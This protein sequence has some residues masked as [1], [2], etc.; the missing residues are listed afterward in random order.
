MENQ[1]GIRLLSIH[2]NQVE[3]ENLTA[4]DHLAISSPAIGCWDVEDISLSDL[5]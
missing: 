5:A 3:L 1:S 2:P 4:D